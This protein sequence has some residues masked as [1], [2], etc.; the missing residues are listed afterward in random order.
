MEPNCPQFNN[1]ENIEFAAAIKTVCD[2]SKIPVDDLR[3]VPPMAR[4]L[5]ANN[6]IR[7]KRAIPVRIPIHRSL[8]PKSQRIDPHLVMSKL[9]VI[10]S[11]YPMPAR[12]GQIS[13][14]QYGVAEFELLLP[15]RRLRFWGWQGHGHNY[16][17]ST[18][19][20]YFIH[21]DDV[22]DFTRFFKKLERETRVTV[23]P[24]ILANEML[25][26]IYKNSIGFLLRGKENQAVYQKYRIPYKR[27]ILL[28]GRPGCV[29]GKTKIRI[30]KKSDRGTHRIHDV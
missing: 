12:E 7:F 20:M 8:A 24:P 25:D 22:L 23:D 28:S 26:S 9:R 1:D 27:G 2:E 16:F 14:L 11:D 10:T 5:M 15:K 30:R 18:W 4:K 6:K 13:K 21:K 17:L 29:T 19:S 3:L